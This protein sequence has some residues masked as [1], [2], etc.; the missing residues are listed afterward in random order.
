MKRSQRQPLSYLD[1]GVNINEGNALICEIAPLL[2]TTSRIGADCN[3]KGFGGLFDLNACN[4]TDPI[5]VSAS[6]GVG[7]KLLIAIESNIQEFIGIDLVAMCVND[8]LVHGAEPLFFLDYFS[9]GTLDKNTASTIISGIVNGCKEAGAALIGGE[10]AEM[11]GLYSEHY[12]DLAG[13]SVGAVE[14]NHILPLKNIEQ[15]D[16]ILGIAS[17]GIHSNGFSL[18]RKIVKISGL[19]WDDI[20]PFNPNSSLARALLEPTRIYVQ[21]LLPIIRTKKVKALAHITGGG[22]TE[23]LPRVIPNN[24]AA[25][26][27]LSTFPFPKLFKWLSDLGQVCPREML[28][29]FNCGI[30]MCVIS[31]NKESNSIIKSLS[32]NGE[33]VFRIGQIQKRVNDPITYSGNFQYEND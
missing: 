16:V 12:Y 20:A 10:T 32:E 2:A 26:I 25:E 1:A 14:R 8:L 18:V 19:N 5:L 13:F 24:L 21:S 15:G 31:S 23:N 27:D 29:T 9:C 6:D 22:L 11:P 28:R 17:N 7:T 3:T 33:Q 4:F 30:G